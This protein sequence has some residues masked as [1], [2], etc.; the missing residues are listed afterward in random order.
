MFVVYVVVTSLTMVANAGFALADLLKARFVLHNSAEV[1]V[2]LSWLPVLGMLKG[3]AATGLLLGLLGAR[4]IG[5][6]AAFGLVVFFVGAIGAHLRA[7]VFYN[8][9]FP[10]ACLALAI[11]SLALAI[12]R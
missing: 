8:L 9:P 7:R 5:A 11:A 12:T 10:G 2:P 4:W 1:G 6:A 3:L